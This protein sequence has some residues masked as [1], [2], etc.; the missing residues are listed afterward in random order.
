MGPVD[1]AWRWGGGIP[2]D[3]VSKAKKLLVGGL[4]ILLNGSREDQRQTTILRGYLKTGF[5]TRRLMHGNLTGYSLEQ[6][7]DRSQPRT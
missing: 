1:G 4:S 2:L 3:D 7:V 5:G 6:G